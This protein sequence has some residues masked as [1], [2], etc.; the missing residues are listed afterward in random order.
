MTALVSI[1]ACGLGMGV[2]IGVANVERACVEEGVGEWER[3][4][5]RC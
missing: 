4:N 5:V 3:A 2:V 1:E